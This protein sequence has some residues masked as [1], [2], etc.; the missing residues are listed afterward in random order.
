MPCHFNLKAIIY[1]TMNR[2][3]CAHGSTETFSADAVTVS[4]HRHFIRHAKEN[5][6]TNAVGMRPPYVRQVERIIPKKPPAERVDLRLG[7]IKV[8]IKNAESISVREENG[9]IIIT[10]TDKSITTNI[11]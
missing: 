8:Q 4:N 11:A 1:M 6:N 5:R 3:I 10:L 7:K 9:G 2:T